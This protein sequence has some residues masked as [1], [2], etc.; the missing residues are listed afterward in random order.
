MLSGCGA[1]RERRSDEG[2]MKAH[3]CFP[4]PAGWYG[5]DGAGAGHRGMAARP[6]SCRSARSV[7]GSLHAVQHAERAFE[8]VRNSVF[9]LRKGSSDGI[10]G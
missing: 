6:V 9:K 8:D 4:N 7:R 3:S 10:H 1:S 2:R 5:A